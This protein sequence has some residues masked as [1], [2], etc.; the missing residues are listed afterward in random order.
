MMKKKN[1]VNQ[2]AAAPP[3]KVIQ[4]SKHY[5]VEAPKADWPKILT[6]LVNTLMFPCAVVFADERRPEKRE[7]VLADMQ[8]CGLAVRKD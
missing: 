7:Q 5:C 6:G 2:V 1:L 4:A 8:K 3:T